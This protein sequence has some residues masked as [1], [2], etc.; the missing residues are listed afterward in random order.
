M[1]KI[2]TSITTLL[3]AVVC[4][5][6]FAQSSGCEYDL[7][8][9]ESVCFGAEFTFPDG[10][11]STNVISQV[12]HTSNLQT[13]VSAC[14]SIITTTVNPYPYNFTSVTTYD[15]CAGDVYTFPDGTVVTLEGHTEHT[16]TI[17]SLV[18]GC[19]SI[20]ETILNTSDINLGVSVSGN[21]LTSQQ[22]NAGFQWVDCDN[23]YATINGAGDQSFAAPTG[24]FAVII[25]KGGCVDTSECQQV[26]TV[27]ISDLDDSEALVYPNPTKG[28]FKVNLGKIYDRLTAT[29]TNVMGQQLSSNVYR[30]V[31]IV[32][33]QV[34][35]VDGIYFIE[36]RS[37]NGLNAT[38]RIVKQ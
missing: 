5:Q 28:E 16:S 31:S 27:G 10:T 34:Q 6:S 23:A 7:Q 35:E 14:D 37:E 18:T 12:V 30:N 9:S 24:N 20:I 29:I 13:V 3:L 17:Q 1:K 8:V 38:Y 19:D 32:D 15:N 11:I 36:L 25:Y 4:L 22:N 33:M 2:F 21:T 26:M